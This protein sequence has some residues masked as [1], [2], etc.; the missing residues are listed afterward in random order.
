M[1]T[2][3]QLSTYREYRISSVMLK[4]PE[5][6]VIVVWLPRGIGPGENFLT[7]YD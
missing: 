3:D 4:V 2:V 5:R 6:I 7:I 1:F